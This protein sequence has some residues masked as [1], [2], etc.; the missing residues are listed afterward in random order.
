M[1][2]EENNELQKCII[3]LYYSFLSEVRIVSYPRQI[4]SNS[5]YIVIKLWSLLLVLIALF[6]ASILMKPPNLSKFSLTIAVYNIH[7]PH[8][9]F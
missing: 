4:L 3:A 5:S 2:I 8:S 7:L 9:P 1:E 6:M